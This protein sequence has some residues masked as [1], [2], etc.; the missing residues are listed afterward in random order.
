MVRSAIIWVKIRYKNCKKKKQK[1]Q[2]NWK[3]KAF[4]QI[5]YAT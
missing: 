4:L 1:V 3:K 5:T 2:P